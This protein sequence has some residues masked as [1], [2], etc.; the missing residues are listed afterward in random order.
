MVIQFYSAVFIRVYFLL[1]NF[2]VSA[3]CNVSVCQLT[4]E[5][6]DGFELSDEQEFIL[7]TANESNPTFVI[8]QRSAE[9]TEPFVGE[10]S[11][12]ERDAV[13]EF[14]FV[15]ATNDGVIASSGDTQLTPIPVSL[16][17]VRLFKLPCVLFDCFM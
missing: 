8:K 5:T 11:Y 14:V 6:S 2:L 16:S 10:T 4:V 7:Y 13:A 15:D 12:S 17:I 9:S 1:H 3:K